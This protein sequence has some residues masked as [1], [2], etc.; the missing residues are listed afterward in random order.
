M[1]GADSVLEVVQKYYNGS[2]VLVLAGIFAIMY[3]GRTAKEKKAYMIALC[4]CLCLLFN[5]ISYWLIK[6]IGEEDTY[7]RFLW[8]MPCLILCG[9]L[10]MEV[11]EKLQSKYQK[12]MMI[13]V[14]AVV[15]FLYGSDNVGKFF[16]LPEN[17]YQ[18]PQRIVDICDI[19]EADRPEGKS[20]VVFAEDGVLD[21]ARE[22]NAN[23]NGV[24]EGDVEYLEI[25]M[26]ANDSNM[27]GTLLKVIIKLAK[28]DYIV[29]ANEDNAFRAA[30]M[31]AGCTVVG[32]TG[33]YMIL[34]THLQEIIEIFERFDAH[35]FPAEIETYYD[36]NVY[37]GTGG[38]YEFVYYPDN[39][40]AL[41]DNETGKNT[42]LLTED[43]EYQQV[44]YDDFIIC[45]INTDDDFIE[46]VTVEKIKQ[47]S[48]GEKKVI[49]L[50]T[51]PIY[52]EGIVKQEGAMLF[53]E[54]LTAGETNAT[55]LVELVTAEENSI[56]AVFS[57][58]MVEYSKRMLNENVW[59]CVCEA[60]NNLG[61]VIRIK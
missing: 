9:L 50:V 26:D 17:I 12:I 59:Q 52:Q 20:V 21:G 15:F 31:S 10:A 7:Y 61:T 16:K 25:M 1:N 39:H 18:I 41:V 3:F 56:V 57:C 35:E 32:D 37:V 48:V 34:N 6:K 45:A 22:Y 49:L 8:I 4:I 29:V 55:E 13:V 54:E 19:I 40:I 36:E 51:N 2:I 11:F 58:G 28:I 27:M 30:M 53:G 46:S 14:C 44:E 33:E 5:D 38:V 24:V 42:H 23:I 60:D 47:V 43:V